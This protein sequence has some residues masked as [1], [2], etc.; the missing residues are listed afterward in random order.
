LLS[1][2]SISPGKTLKSLV[3]GANG[4]LGKYIVEQL[5]AAGEEVRT[6]TRRPDADLQKLDVECQYADIRDAASVARAC[7]DCETVYHVAGLAGIWGRAQEY[8]GVNVQGTRN[9]VEGCCQQHVRKL[10]YTSSPSVVFGGTDHCGANEQTPY[11]KKWLNH[12][13]RTKA[14][15][16]QA[17]LQANNADGTLTCALR[18]HLIWGPRDQHLIPRVINR[19][20]QGKLRQVGDGTNLVDNIFVENAAEAHLLAA[21]ALAENPES[22]GRAYFLSQ[23]DPV[24]C[25]DWINQILAL[26]GVPPIRKKISYPLA[27]AIGATAETVY[28][29]TGR[30]SEPVMTRFLAGQL[31]KSHY[32]D[33]TAARELLGYEP[34]VSLE[35]GMQLLQEW[36]DSAGFSGHAK[37]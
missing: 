35:T 5:L 24:R 37:V 22:T 19:A 18:P 1:C 21:R 16:E 29:L 20:R 7:A 27:Y 34:R 36:I 12:Y 30:T 9:I 25:W 10:I 33:I 15:G 13:S 3:T 11:P 28:R 17:V 6:L 2:N 26:A 23:G 14:L 4:F 32:F 8:H 31:A